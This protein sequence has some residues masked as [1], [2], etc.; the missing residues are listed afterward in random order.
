MQVHKQK[1][2]C[3]V[4]GVCVHAPECMCVCV[5][6]Y[7]SQLH[8]ALV[9]FL[10]S[11]TYPSYCP[12]TPCTS[13]HTQIVCKRP[14]VVYVSMCRVSTATTHANLSADGDLLSGSFILQTARS[15]SFYV[16]SSAFCPTPLWI[17]ICMWTQLV[18]EWGRAP[19]RK[20]ISGVDVVWG[21]FF[22]FDFDFQSGR[23]LSWSPH[24][25]LL[26]RGQ[27]FCPV[28]QKLL[29]IL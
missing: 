9:K 12:T 15:L 18:V 4:K 16:N 8:K 21:I 2:Y 10:M 17:M 25:A 3:S 14:R 1:L 6:Y 7:S 19:K 5:V 13:P 22:L 28:A 20:T 11:P 26:N 24:Q 23:R 27:K 29:K